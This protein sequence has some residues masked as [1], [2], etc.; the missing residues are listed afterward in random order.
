MFNMSLGILVAM[1]LALSKATR[2]FHG[3]GCN[4]FNVIRICAKTCFDILDRRTFVE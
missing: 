4:A 2:Q 1:A 3:L